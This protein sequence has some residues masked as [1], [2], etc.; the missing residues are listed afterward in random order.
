[1]QIK[2]GKRGRGYLNNS[3]TLKDAYVF[4][5][6]ECKNKNLKAVDKKT[7][8]KICKD[9]NK[10]IMNLVLN[11]S[12]EVDL[13][14]RMGSIKVT[15]KKQDLSNKPQNKWPIDWKRSKEL[16]F[17]V[18][19]VQDYTYNIKWLKKRALVR[20]KKAY[21]FKPCRTAKRQVPKN[22]KTKKID[23]FN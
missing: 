16:G 2:I 18:Y 13:P 22:L 11:K 12:E 5:K 1:M 15:K 10:E 3:K 21:I 17:K 19:F 20:F 14:F 7:F 4:Y 9:T 6:Q 23:Y 8:T